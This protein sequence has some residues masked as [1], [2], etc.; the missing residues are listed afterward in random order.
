[1]DLPENPGIWAVLRQT[2]DRGPLRQLTAMQH[3][4]NT[5]EPQLCVGRLSS[6]PSTRP[7]AQRCLA[8]TQERLAL[9]TNR[10]FSKAT[11]VQGRTGYSGAMAW[12]V[13][14]ISL[15]RTPDHTGTA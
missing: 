1:M 15:L 6:T 11:T 12:R 3:P 5:Q 9:N 4:Q 10:S 7:Q 8:T 14:G 13:D 2:L